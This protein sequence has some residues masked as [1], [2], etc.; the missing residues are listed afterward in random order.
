M[1][2]ACRSVTII[3]LSD[4]E[5]DGERKEFTLLEGCSFKCDLNGMIDDGVINSDETCQSGLN[6]DP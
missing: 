6:S 4:L 2:C 5:H 1:N 3:D